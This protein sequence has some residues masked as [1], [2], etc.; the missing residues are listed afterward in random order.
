MNRALRRIAV[1]VLAVLLVFILMIGP[2]LL[3]PPIVLLIG[4]GFSAVRLFKAWQPDRTAV[5]LFALATIVLV[6]GTQRLCQ[7]LYAS[8]RGKTEDDL[9]SKWAWK[10]TLSGFGIA[11]C[12]LVA[13]CSVV[14]TTHQLYWL[15]KSSDPL[16]TD[17]F[18]E[19][20][21][22]V[23][24]ARALLEDA[25]DV[26]WDAVKTRAAFWQKELTARGQPAAE[27]FQPVWIEQ[28]ARRLRAVILLPRRPMHGARASLV[29]I[30]PGTNFMTRRLDELPQ[31]LASF[32]IGPGAEASKGPL[33]LLP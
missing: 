6:A 2:G 27:A 16:F 25:E 21:G 24:V 17:S 5:V 28:D 4:W 22:M 15:S 32:G 20:I 14:L 9:P 11:F 7:W 12:T 1:A 18:R 30:E 10:W 8:M 26:Q 33:E 13:L 23:S 19:R 29:I 31:V 3:E